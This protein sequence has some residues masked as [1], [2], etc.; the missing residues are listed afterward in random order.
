MRIIRV[1]GVFVGSLRGLGAGRLFGSFSRL[2]F[3]G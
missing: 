2:L 3:S 1:N